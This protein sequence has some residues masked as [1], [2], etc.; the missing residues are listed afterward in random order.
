MVE[1][2]KQKDKLNAKIIS[3]HGD[4][5]SITE[6]LLPNLSDSQDGLDINANYQFD[7]ERYKSILEGALNRQSNSSRQLADF[8]YQN[9]DQYLSD[10]EGLLGK[11]ISGALTLKGGYT[12]QSLATALLT[13]CFYEV[14]YDLVYEDD[15]F[16]QMSDGKKA[17]VVL[18][19]LL[20]FSD[21]KCPILIDQP[22]DD[23]DNRAIYLDLVQ[24]LKKKK[25][26]R[27]IIV[28]THNPNIV[29]GSDSELVIVANQHGVKN[30]NVGSKKFAYKSGSLENTEPF[31]PSSPI[32]L[33]SQG[34]REHVCVILEGGDVAFKLREKKYAIS[35]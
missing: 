33:D 27:Q 6:S 18:K 35:S 34:I 31:D 13:E 28:A 11:L 14:S 21:K 15:N 16:K 7:D 17:F 10:L 23:L 12:S 2:K 32:V 1:L 20:D 19:L 3:N 9:H 26:Q 30:E 5:Y 29:V 25:I 24:Y 4:Y 8:E 22:E